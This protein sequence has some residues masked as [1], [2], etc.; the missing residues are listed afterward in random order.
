MIHRSQAHLLADVF[1]E[2]DQSYTEDGCNLVD[3]FLL[4]FLV[5]GAK[6]QKLL[7]VEDVS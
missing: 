7:D 5:L 1:S 6:M 3:R 2:G 4:I